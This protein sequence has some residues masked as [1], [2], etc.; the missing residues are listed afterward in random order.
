[1]QSKSLGKRGY[2]LDTHSL[3]WYFTG[4]KTL[5]AR[6]LAILEEVF[7]RKAIGVIPSI[8]LL[9]AL[10]VS[11]KHKGFVFP[12]FLDSLRLP[13]IL[14][15]PLDKE[16]LSEGFTLPEVLDIHDRVV[17][18]TTLVSDTKL[19]TKDEIITGSGVVDTVW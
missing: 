10:H 13:N 11:Y 1:M 18:A 12:K 5:S 3:V 7:L 6:A 17:V 16:V 2:C 19:V 4:S 8:V 14:I 15:Y 9:E